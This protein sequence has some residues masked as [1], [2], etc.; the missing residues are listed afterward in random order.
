ML[1]KYIQSKTAITVP[2]TA[3][4]LGHKSPAAI[5]PSNPP[6]TTQVGLSR[7]DLTSK[8]KEG[9]NAELTP[10]DSPVPHDTLVKKKSVKFILPDSN[11]MD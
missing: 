10:E 3:P 9:N 11:S 5:H 7:I 6:P 1:Q 2:V 4:T 8:E